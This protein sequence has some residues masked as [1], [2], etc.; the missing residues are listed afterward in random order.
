LNIVDPDPKAI[1]LD[2]NVLSTDSVEP[3]SAGCVAPFDRANLPSSFVELRSPKFVELPAVLIV[4]NAISFT[5]SA[6]TRALSPT[7]LVAIQL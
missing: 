4:M 7:P 6:P 3:G 5:S 2:V 1:E